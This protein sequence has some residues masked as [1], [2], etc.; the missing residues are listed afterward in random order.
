MRGRKRDIMEK[1][2]KILII[3]DDPTTAYLHER[4]IDGFGVAHQ[5]EI[6][7]SGED[8]L[9]MIWNHIRT[10][11]EDKIPQLIFVDLNMP[12]MDGFEFLEAYERLNFE[13]KDSVVVSVLTSSY[14]S[15]DI[16]RVKEFPAVNDYVVKPL[17]EEKVME[18]MQKHFGW[19]AHGD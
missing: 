4:L 10:Q 3:E 15:K 13:N 19:H 8:A 16:N 9:Q 5:V 12:T 7:Y 18:L 11:N 2:T 17:T 6:A 1:L 14:H